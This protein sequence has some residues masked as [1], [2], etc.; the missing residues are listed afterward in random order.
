MVVED[1]KYAY[2]SNLAFG[3]LFL[4]A[5]VFY[6]FRSISEPKIKNWI[7]FIV[8]ILI[9][10]TWFVLCYKNYKKHKEIEKR[11]DTKK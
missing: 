11:L 7:V 10:L 9:S 2:K 6:F 8:S 4:L 3:I 5:S 1:K